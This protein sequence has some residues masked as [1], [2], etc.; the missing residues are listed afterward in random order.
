[1]ALGR[2][3]VLLDYHLRVGEVARDTRV[4]SGQ[5]LREQRLDE[6]VTGAGTT[7]TQARRLNDP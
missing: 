1:M 2:S 5:V 4:P 7:V 3:H 6:T